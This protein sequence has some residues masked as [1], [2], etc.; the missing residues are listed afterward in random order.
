M[1]YPTMEEVERADREQL[2][3]WWRFLRSADV[4][5]REEMM[6]Q[7]RY[8]ERYREVGGMTPAISKRI[9]WKRG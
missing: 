3:R 4:H 8:Q 7:D 9:G 1:N 5:S 6:I 2:C